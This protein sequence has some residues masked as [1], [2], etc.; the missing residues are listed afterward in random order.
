MNLFPVRSAGWFQLQLTISCPV[1]RHQQCVAD[2][3]KMLSV[4]WL[5]GCWLN[6]E[7]VKRPFLHRAMNEALFVELK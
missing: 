1:Q 4:T 6:R 3:M 2:E 7:E 5:W